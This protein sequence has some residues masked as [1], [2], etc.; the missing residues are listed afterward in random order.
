LVLLSPTIH[1]AAW[2][3]FALSVVGSVSLDCDE[4]IDDIWKGRSVRKSIGAGAYLFFV[5][6]MWKKG[7]T[8]RRVLL[9]CSAGS[10]VYDEMNLATRTKLSW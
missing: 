7:S 2:R 6:I 8:N 10:M 5:S 9:V 3:R 4:A 1:C